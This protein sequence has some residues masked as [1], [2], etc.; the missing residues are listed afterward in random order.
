MPRDGTNPTKQLVHDNFK[1][2]VFALFGALRYDASDAVELSLALR[3]DREERDVTNLVPTDARTQFIDF[4]LDGQFTG[5][6]PLNPGLDPI[7]NP[8]GR[9]PPK[10]AT[11]DELQP[12]LSATWDV[13]ERTTLFG[14]WGV[15]FKT[16]GFNNQGSN[17]TVDIFYNNAIG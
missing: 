15:G 11:F 16:G 17:A 7:I 8:S 10:S 2:D 12:K 5:G 1:T 14:S 6:A 3:Y 13:G 4:T 9:I